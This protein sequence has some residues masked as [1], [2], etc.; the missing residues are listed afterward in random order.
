MA[1]L[2]KEKL[3]IR[4]ASHQDIPALVELSRKLYPHD[5]FIPE[6]LAGQMSIFPEGQFVAVY[7]GNVV[8]H[9]VTFI[10]DGEIALKPHGWD[11]ITGNGFASRHDPDGDYLYG[12]E[13]YIDT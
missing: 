10:I 11:E 5:H 1:R 3:T 4:L 12:M 7:D 2:D 6:M 8:G 9:C 13:V